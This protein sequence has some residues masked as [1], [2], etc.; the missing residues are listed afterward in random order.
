[1]LIRSYLQDKTQITVID[2]RLSN[3]FAVTYELPQGSVLGPLHVLFLLY[4]I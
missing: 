4:I 2:Q 1:M 3:K